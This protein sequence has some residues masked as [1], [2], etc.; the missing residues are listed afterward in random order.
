[1][2]IRD[3]SSPAACAGFALEGTPGGLS[4]HLRRGP[5]AAR[6]DPAVRGSRIRR[7]GGMKASPSFGVMV[8]QNAPWPVLLERAR[9]VEAMGFDTLWVGDHF[10]NPYAPDQDWFEGWTLLAALAASTSRIR[11][12]PLV[13]SVTLRSPA[14]L[15]RMALTVDHVSGGR[16]EL[17]IGPGG[18]PLDYRMTGLPTWEPRERVDRLEETLTIVSALLERGSVHHE[19]THYRIDDAILNPRPV[20]RPRPCLLYTSPSPRDRTRSRMPS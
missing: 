14:L 15:A 10:V 6:Y 18:A 12:G 9:R 20:Q 2:C 8:L 3:S 1:M 19:G 13:S 16:L 11:L 4:F 5:G 17:G 7:R